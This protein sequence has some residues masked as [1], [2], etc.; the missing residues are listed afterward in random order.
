MLSQMRV[1]ASGF[2]KGQ[3][4]PSFR[5]AGERKTGFQLFRAMR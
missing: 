2:K 5:I 4:A 3:G 1:L